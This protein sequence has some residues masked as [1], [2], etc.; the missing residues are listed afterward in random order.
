MFIFIKQFIPLLDYYESF[1]N[2][3][4]WIGEHILRRN[5]VDTNKIVLMGQSQ[6]AMVV[7]NALRSDSHVQRNYVAAG[8]AYYPH[9]GY[10][11]NM[12][13]IPNY[14]KYFICRN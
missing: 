10:L 8:I 13:S 14:K 7:L 12:F 6:G 5:Y 9:C 2:F 4:F 1:W 11:K 3:R